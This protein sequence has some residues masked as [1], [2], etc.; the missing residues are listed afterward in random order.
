MFPID[1][2]MLIGISVIILAF[3]FIHFSDDMNVDH[4]YTGIVYD[5]RSTSNGYTFLFDSSEGEFKCYC[6]ERPVDL[7]YYGIRGQFSNDGSI[8][9]IDRLTNI[10]IYYDQD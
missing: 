10:D 6:S 8:F 9:F 5:I 3:L 1:K 4:D 2:Y 7:G